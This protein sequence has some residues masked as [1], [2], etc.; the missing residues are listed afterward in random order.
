[1]CEKLKIY[2]MISCLGITNVIFFTFYLDNQAKEKTTQNEEEGHG[3]KFF[4]LG[5]KALRRINS[6]K[7][8]QIENKSAKDNKVLKS[9][10]SKMPLQVLVSVLLVMYLFEN[11]FS[12]VAICFRFSERK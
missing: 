11:I 7:S 3:S 6:R 9:P 10:Q 8:C 4:D 2:L 12:I 5:S 1:M